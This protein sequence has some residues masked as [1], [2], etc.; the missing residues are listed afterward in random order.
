[1]IIKSPVGMPGR[2]VK[3]KFIE[4]VQ[5]APGGVKGCYNCLKACNPATAEYC[6]SQ[7]LINAVE[8]NLDEGLIFC[9]LRTGEIREISTVRQVVEELLEC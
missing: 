2:A 5:N 1:M 7:A 3:N 8:G 6:I 4:K 9:G